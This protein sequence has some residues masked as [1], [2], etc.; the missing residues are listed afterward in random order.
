MRVF[1]V[2]L[3]AFVVAGPAY[4]QVHIDIGIRLPSPPRLVVVPEVRSV[5]YVPDVQANLFFYSGQYWAFSNG[6][7][8]VSRGYNGPWIVVA[9]NVVPRSV[10]LVP[11]NYYHARP[12]NWNQWH[13]QQPPRWG[14]EWGPEWAQRREWRDR[15][16][17]HGR[18]HGRSNAG[19]DRRSD[20]RRDDHGRGGPGG[21]GRSK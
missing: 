14:H 4:A 8:H 19:K 6:G 20:D 2:L 10:L 21:P 5:Q 12:S 13:R 16:D 18:G 11:V 1:I 3:L 15:D 17:D 9:P 7:W